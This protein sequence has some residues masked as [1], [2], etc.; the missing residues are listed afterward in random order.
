MT[1]AQKQA[2]I[3]KHNEMRALE[4]GADMNKLVYNY[5]SINKVIVDLIFG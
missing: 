4:K 5:L 2:I 1:D 3:D